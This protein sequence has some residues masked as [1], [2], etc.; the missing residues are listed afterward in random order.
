MYESYVGVLLPPLMGYII[1][2]VY[3][4]MNGK[5]FYKNMGSKKQSFL[6]HKP[7][8]RKK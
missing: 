4:Y 7:F 1:S 5:S 6:N 8:Q 3:C 2:Q